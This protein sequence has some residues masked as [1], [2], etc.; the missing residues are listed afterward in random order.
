[1]SRTF[2]LAVV[3]LLAASFPSTV[4]AQAFCTDEVVYWSEHFGTGTTASSHPDIIPGSLTYQASGELVNEGTYRV[5]NNTEQ[6]PGWHN[7]DDHTA[8]DTDG[9]A[10]I[11]NG[12][13]ETFFSHTTT[14]VTGFAA[15]NYSAS[16]YLM[17][18]NTPGT[19][20]PNPLLPEITF[21]IEYLSASN[22]WVELTNSPVSSAAVP[23]SSNPTW[24]SLGGV[25]VLPSTA[26]FVVTQMRITL[27]DGVSGGCGNDFA[28]DDL[29][30]AT[31][32]S[33]SPLP[34]AFL[35]IDAKRQG[36][37]VRVNWSTASETNNKQFE[38]ERSTNGGI[39]WNT[40]AVIPSR[41]NSNTIKNYNSFD[42]KPVDGD[43]F[44]RIRQTHIDGR[45]SFS[46]VASVKFVSGNSGITILSNPFN[47]SISMD[48]MSNKA[49]ALQCSLTDANGRRVYSTVINVAKGY[50][51]KNIS[52]LPLMA[53][54]TYVLQVLA[55]DGSTLTTEKLLKQ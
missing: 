8:G 14:V 29:K 17:N 28:I 32:P 42:P 36:S 39:R 23:Q 49:Q 38:V 12:N 1:M 27:S 41:D 26:P 35:G 21:K 15:G 51:R 37:G 19:C 33:G 53:T 11:I 24:I 47:Q 3:L 7:T 45:F 22:S 5:I 52:S 4:N 43:N 55:E 6:Y 50:N 46:P 30:L 34:V 18:L 20:A 2:L 9:K 40:I 16:L 48:I 31:C 13:S 25:F 54:G 44:Y 10:L